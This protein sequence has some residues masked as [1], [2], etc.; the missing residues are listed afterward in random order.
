[1]ACVKKLTVGWALWLG[2]STA[3]AGAVLSQCDGPSSELL[4][5]ASDEPS[6]AEAVWLDQQRLVWPSVTPEFAQIEAQGEQLELQFF[7]AEA[8][9]TK[10]DFSVKL[11]PDPAAVPARFDYLRRGGNALQAW[12]VASADQAKVDTHRAGLWLLRHADKTGKTL[13]RTGLQNANRLDAQFARSEQ[14]SL[15]V[16]STTTH[17]RFT[18]WAPTARRVA[19][20]V[21]P[22]A[23]RAAE[24]IL[25]MQFQR[26]TGAWFAQQQKNR[27]GQYYRYVIELYVPKLG[28]VRNLVSDPYAISAGANGERSYI[29]DLSSPELAPKGW[30]EQIKP[31]AL[32]HNVDGVIYELHLRDFSVSDDSV[33][34]ANRGRYL[35]FTEARSRGTRHLRALAAAGLTDV[36]LLP[37]FDFA[38]VPEVGCKSPK[39]PADAGADSEA[40]Q[41]AIAALKAEDCF[42]WGYDPQHFGAPEGSYASD[43]NDGAARIREFR[44]MVDALHRA[45][46]RVGMDVVYNHTSHAG[47]HAFSVLDRIVPGYYHRLNPRGEIERSTCCENTATEHRMM[48]K[49]MIDTA[50]R[51]V[52]DYRIDS[53]RFDLMGHQPLAAM[54]D[55][56]ARLNAVSKTPIVLLGEGW[57]FGEVA[58]N[59]RFVQAAQLSLGGSGIASFSDR[60]RDAARGGGCCDSGAALFA[61]QGF[62]N[63]LHYAP[64]GSPRSAV[65][66]AASPAEL[67]RAA[68]LI[69][70]GLAGSLR[71]F[72]LQTHDGKTQTLEKIDYVGQPAG[73]VQQPGEV[74]NYVENH[75]NPTL[76]DLNVLKLPRA[77]TAAERA[78]VQVL[79]ISLVALSQGIAYYH[80]GI[81]AL[82]SKSLDRN[83]FDSGDWFN[84]LDW[85]FEDNFFASGLPPKSENGGNYEAFAPLLRTAHIKP[86]PAEIRWTRDLFLA[87]LKIRA[88]T[89]LLRLPQAEQVKSRLQFLPSDP[90]QASWVAAVLDGQNL[91]DASFARLAY[92]INA[93]VKAQRI[94]A[95]SEQAR[96]YQLHPVMRARDY[97]DTRVRQALYDPA[98]GTFTIPARTAVVFVIENEKN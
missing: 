92:F 65:E 17:T 49:L 45:G 63:G 43:A 97:P 76:F 71:E 13:A 36:H 74:V 64:N 2:I 61:K 7:G 39:I 30:N 72:A 93:D 46:L 23:S 33:T 95:K 98:A 87:W 59:A 96:S 89:R 81:E 77:T 83:S 58:N 42:N 35:A 18:L 75:D 31:R 47:Q 44:A 78:R 32:H 85:R 41:A 6:T 19:V 54:Q 68:D 8:S 3:Q 82:R 28:W 5:A 90:K 50:E 38:S 94:Q 24:A 15:G 4:H 25:T 26:D 14:L 51:W 52:R 56:Q 57:N 91:A 48:A 66:T 79:G 37:V 40:Q 60:A 73:Y 67:A 80:A 86:K 62:L 22:D 21:Y 70:V 84:R 55:L 11:A 53:F 9:A 12:R 10:A 16:Q 20:C 69:K 1:M 29:H 27:R 88:S 34:P